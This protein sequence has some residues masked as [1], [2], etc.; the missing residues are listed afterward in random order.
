MLQQSG[1][2][3]TGICLLV[4]HVNMSV[5]LPLLLFKKD[6]D[7]EIYPTL[8]LEIIYYTVIIV[9]KWKRF[10]YPSSEWVVGKL[11]SMPTETN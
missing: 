10:S 11:S 7:F 8:H 5:L 1:C 4:M 9:W 6:I 2:S 3:C